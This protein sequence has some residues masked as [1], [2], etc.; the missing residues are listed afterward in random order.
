MHAFMTTLCQHCAQAGLPLPVVVAAAKTQ[1]AATVRAAIAA[2]LTD[3]GENYVQEAQRKA[4]D[5]AYTGARVHLIGRFQSNK[6]AEVARLFDVVHSLDKASSADKL[7]TACQKA[8]RTLDVFLQVYIGPPRAERA[9]VTPTDL[10]TLADHVRGLS[11][12]RLVGLMCMPTADD[13]DTA[14]TFRTVYTLGQRL[15]LRQFSMGMSG[16][17]RQALACGATHIRVGS[18]LFGARTA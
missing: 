15:G 1:S 8:G 7:N 16:D 5:G 17:W 12:L 10:P 13:H 3:I 6:A 14:S 9:G 2:G 4:A 18:A 11:N